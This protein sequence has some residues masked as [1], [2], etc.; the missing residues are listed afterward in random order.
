MSTFVFTIAFVTAPAPAQAQ[1]GDQKLA[2]QLVDFHVNN[3]IANA[4]IFRSAFGGTIPSEFLGQLTDE[5]QIARAL[6]PAFVLSQAIGNQISSFPLG[7]SAGGF[8]W[9]FDP[10]LGT[11]NRVSESFGPVFSERALTVGRN[12][13]NF[14]LNVQ[15]ATFD[16]IAGRDLSGGEIK[17]YFGV[18]SRTGQVFIEDALKFKVSSDTVGLFGT[19]GLTDRL[20][21]GVVVPLV[22]VAMETAFDSRI[23]SNNTVDPEV[24]AGEPLEGDASGIGDVVLRGKYVLW[25]AA[26]GGVAAGLDVR[27]PT[28]DEENWL[29]VAGPQARLYVATSGAFG[30]IS[31]HFN[32]G[33]TISGE[34]SAAQDVSIP[35]FAPP[36][37]VTY[38][39][40]VDASVTPRLTVVGDLLG[41]S[42]LDYG[43][44]EEQATQFGS[45]FRTLGLTEAGNLNLLLGSVGVKYN[46]MGSSLVAF[47]VLFPVKDNGL[48]DKLTW[49][50][51]FE[52]SFSTRR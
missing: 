22:R 35:V 14:G 11:F 45:G 32:L 41:R 46:V 39:G 20:D 15:R 38:A 2:Q 5:E 6:Q 19:V 26:G 1:D 4:G 31:P 42:L 25:P 13:F 24:F 36:N 3:V 29:G 50:L 17:T 8:S 18:T 30:R 34:S 47:N 44:F 9:T 33:Y 23:G 10:S 12:R 52:H 28:G 48:T 16:S 27:L 21:L 7:S 40:G 51:G 37:E 43:R 49:V